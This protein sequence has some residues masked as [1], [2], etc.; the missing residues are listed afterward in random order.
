MARVQEY[1]LER[2]TDAE[3]V[4]RDWPQLTGSGCPTRLSLLAG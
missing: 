3:A 2:R 1:L 4:R